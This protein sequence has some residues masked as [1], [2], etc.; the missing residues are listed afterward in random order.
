M[1]N[2]I[3]RF[4][5]HEYRSDS[6]EKMIQEISAKA[7]VSPE[8]VRKCSETALT[9][10]ENVGGKDVLTLFTARPDYRSIEID[11][12]LDKLR[13]KLRPIIFSRKKLDRSIEI[14][15]KALETMYK[16]F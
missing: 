14:A 15:S 10:W 13:D 7:S 16:I 8:L 3:T 2:E 1:K 5:S 12:M 11:K 6:F 4:V 9:E